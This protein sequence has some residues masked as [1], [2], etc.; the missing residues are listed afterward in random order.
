MRKK[1][2]NFIFLRENHG[3]QIDDT[4]ARRNRKKGNMII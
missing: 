3:K 2:A 1:P 4:I